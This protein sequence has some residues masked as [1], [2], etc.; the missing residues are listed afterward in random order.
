MPH[1]SRRQFLSSSM[2]IAGAV[3]RGSAPL[4]A[5]EP[6]KRQWPGAHAGRARRLLDARLPAGQARREGRDGSR[7][8]S[9]TGRPRSTPTPWSSPRTSSPTTITPA[10]LNDI[11]RRCH[12][13]GLD[14]SGGAIRN[15]FTLPPDPSSR[16]GSPTSTPGST[17]TPRSARRDSRLCRYSAEG[18]VGGRRHPQRHRRT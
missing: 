5:I 17:T 18:R 12:V 9:S 13:N 7:R 3:G 4:S 10:Y 15:N 8:A 16:S 14:I 2:T 6:I 1:L 11:K